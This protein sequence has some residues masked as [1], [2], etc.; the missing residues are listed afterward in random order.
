M[1][2]NVFPPDFNSLVGQVRFL[3]SDVPADES[4]YVLSDAEIQA[5]LALRKDN[6]TRAAATCLM[7]IAANEVL[8]L[9]YVRT[10][11]LTVDGVKGATELRLQARQLEQQADD[12]DAAD[13]EFFTIVYPQACRGIGYEYQERAIPHGYPEWC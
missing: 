7:S 8:L 1:A 5:A 3:I 2:T 11:D 13:N 4:G 9:K 12:E 6:A 10:D